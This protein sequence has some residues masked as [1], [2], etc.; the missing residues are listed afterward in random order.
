MQV[1]VLSTPSMEFWKPKP[2]NHVLEVSSMKQYAASVSFLLTQTS[3]ITVATPQNVPGSVICFYR[4]VLFLV[5]QHIL[6]H[7]YCRT[8]QMAMCS[9]PGTPPMTVV[10]FISMFE[11]Y[12]LSWSTCLTR[13]WFSE[14]LIQV[15]HGLQTDEMDKTRELLDLVNQFSESAIST[16]VSAYTSMKGSSR[17]HGSR[18]AVCLPICSKLCWHA[19]VHKVLT[20]LTSS[21]ATLQQ[22]GLYALC[23]FI[24]GQGFSR[25][26]NHRKTAL[27]GLDDHI[28][29]FNTLLGTP[30]LGLSS[31][32]FAYVREDLTF[33]IHVRYP[34]R[35]ESLTNQYEVA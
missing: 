9:C 32:E 19:P 25:L 30:D 20:F 28:V 26:A 21:V 11:R 5:W 10:I 7:K 1:I 33:V 22:L 15:W 4:S 8:W 3:I 31:E 27:D 29:C 18:V 14:Y 17:K 24:T 35:S 16:N 2:S 12:C 13:C 23:A 6:T 34:S